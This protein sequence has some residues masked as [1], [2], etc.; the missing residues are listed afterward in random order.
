VPETFPPQGTLFERGGQPAKTGILDLMSRRRILAIAL[1]GLALA[2]LAIAPWTITTTSLTAAVSRQLR[3]MYGLDLTVS[4][5]STIALL[6]MPRLKFEGVSLGLPGRPPLIEANFLRADVRVWPLLLGSVT[7]GEVAL[8]D[9]RVKVDIAEDGASE[10]GPLLMRQRDRIEGQKAI[11][12]HLRRLIMANAAIQVSDKRHGRDLRFDD[13][14]LVVNWP[15]VDASLDLTASFRWRG[16]AVQLTISNLLPLALVRGEKD[17]FAVEASSGHTRLA[18]DLEAALAD[19]VRATG[20]ASFATKGLRD[21]LHWTGVELPFGHFVHAATL[22]GD[23]T[24]DENGVAFPAVQLTVGSDKLDGALSLHFDRGGRPGLTGTLASERLDLSAAPPPFGP[25][26]SSG[27]HWSYER[28]DLQGMG[29]ADLDLRVSAASAR[30]GPLRLEDAAVNLL[31]KPGRVEI[32]LGRATLNKGTVKGR[33]A[34]APGPENHDIRLQGTFDRVD[35]GAFLTDIGHTRWISGLAQGQVNLEGLGESPAELMRRT[36]GRA[37][38]T[39]RQ[40]DLWGVAFAEALR[41]LERRPLSA[42]LEWKGGRTAFDQANLV[43]N[44]HAGVGDVLD[45]ALTGPTARAG[46]QGRVSLVDRSLALRAAVEP[47]AT[48]GTT[49]SQSL[50]LDIQGPWSDV[51]VVPDARILIQRSGAARQLFTSEPRGEDA[52]RPARARAE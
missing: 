34:V 1:A 33:L 26:V 32:A 12:R 31:V 43:L 35:L 25:L 18:F 24:L 2:A 50:L 23:F 39:V 22:A 36:N 30:I 41:R 7:F 5:R 19:G 21:V 11:S 8:Q 9:A 44:V 37:A 6:P 28:L 17:R 3:S 15:A 29:A 45:A 49:A 27:G 40:G 51:S 47:V 13:V 20:K 46:A 4:G 10:W 38:V 48:P 42:P 16:E 52:A 14:N